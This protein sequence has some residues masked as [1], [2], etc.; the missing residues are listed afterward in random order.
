MEDF[1][2]IEVVSRHSKLIMQDRDIKKA[3]PLMTPP[4]SLDNYWY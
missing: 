4:R 3:W 2:F 1:L